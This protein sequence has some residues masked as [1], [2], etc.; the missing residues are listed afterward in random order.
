M[1]SAIEIQ[2]RHADANERL[3]KHF[4]AL[5]GFNQSVTGFVFGLIRVEQSRRLEQRLS[6][7]DTRRTEF[8]Q[9]YGR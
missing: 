8:K 2:M 4:A 5:R 9:R 6:E 7:Y 1:T 3:N